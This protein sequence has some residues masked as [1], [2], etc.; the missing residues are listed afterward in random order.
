MAERAGFCAWKRIVFVISLSAF[1]CAPSAYGYERLFRPFAALSI[2]HFQER[3][4]FFGGID[5][6]DAF[7]S[8]WI[9]MTYAPA[10]TL[11]E[12]GWRIRLSGG[13]GHYRY[14]TS[15]VPG[16]VNEAN[17]YTA[18][19][20]GGY[21]KTYEN[22]LGQKV[23]LGFFAGVNHETQLLLFA[24]RF[25]PTQGAEIGAK[26][27]FEFYSRIANHFILTGFVTASSAHMKYNAKTSL[28]YELSERWALGGEI[29]AMGDARYTEY[30]AGLAASLTW[31][32][33][34]FSLSSGLL[35]NTGRG[36]GVYATFS[37]YSPY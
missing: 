14:R 35:E 2:P 12:D 21:R 3:V 20:L 25:N 17:T 10:G 6:S 9:G 36:S 1:L 16:G 18:E 19:L 13:A 5:A 27:A 23:Y 28:F 15:I 29:V 7:T 22:I 33:K 24:D 32:R 37:V 26:A 34:I 11:L 8:T 31:Q 30:R 4:D